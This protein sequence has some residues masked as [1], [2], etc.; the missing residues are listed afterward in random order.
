LE[1][2]DE[3]QSDKEA[4]IPEIKGMPLLRVIGQLGSTYIAAEGPDGLYLIDQHAAH[5]RVLYEKLRNT[6][7]NSENA[8]QYLLEPETVYLGS[9]LQNWD[10]SGLDLL[11]K[12]GFILNPFGPD[13]YKITA[14]PSIIAHM[15]PKEAFLSAIEPDED[16]QDVV[17]REIVGRIVSRICK[18]AA[19]KGG[20]VLSLQEQEKLVRDLENCMSPRTCPHGRPTMIYLSVNMLER[21]FGR[22]GSI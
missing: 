4:R 19:V 16:D 3:N 18:R 21:Q 20:Q 10:E 22:Q 11:E 9:G 5:E 14:V 1:I 13:T 17:E 2:P 7:E 12:M 15:D 8:S 6:A